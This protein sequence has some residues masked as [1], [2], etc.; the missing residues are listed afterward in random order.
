MTAGRASGK[1]SCA[2][3]CRALILSRL[4]FTLLVCPVRV[5]E[6]VEGGGEAGMAAGRAIV[7]SGR[8]SIA[9]RRRA[10]R[11]KVDREH[12]PRSA[13]CVGVLD[14]AEGSCTDVAEGLDRFSPQLPTQCRLHRLCDLGHECGV[15]GRTVHSSPEKEGSSRH[16]FF[17]GGLVEKSTPANRWVNMGSC[18]I[19]VGSEAEESCWPRA[20]L[21]PQELVQVL[22]SWNVGVKPKNAQGLGQGYHFP[23]GSG[24]TFSHYM[25]GGGA[26]GK[27]PS[28]NLAARRIN[29]FSRLVADRTNATVDSDGAAGVKAAVDDAAALRSSVRTIWEEALGGGK[30]L[31]SALSNLIWF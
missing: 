30:A 17:I 15:A 19:T 28:V 1:R 16:A 9:R 21:N 11:S 12:G 29:A 26:E 22:G 6:G 5:G 31:P 2:S 20:W 13:W 25:C 18:E 8:G 14:A 23:G 4:D 24:D 10:G 3:L 7:V 27:V